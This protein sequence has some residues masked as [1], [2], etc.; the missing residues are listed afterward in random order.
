MVISVTDFQCTL[1]IV[2]LCMEGQVSGIICYF[3]DSIVML[4]LFEILL[5]EMV[6]VDV[7]EIIILI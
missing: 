1:L 5:F 6:L 2:V 3:G 7:N 4:V